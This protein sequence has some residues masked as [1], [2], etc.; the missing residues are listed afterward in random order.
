MG[1]LD[2]NLNRQDKHGQLNDVEMLGVSSP[3]L[4]PFYV[5]TPSVT[6]HLL[7]SQSQLE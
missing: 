2:V 6:S 3:S 5:M 1:I 7:S 4:L